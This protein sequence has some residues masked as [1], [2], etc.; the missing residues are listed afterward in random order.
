MGENISDLDLGAILS[1]IKP[2]LVTPHL[3]DI[4]N[5]NND[6]KL[7]EVSQLI[8]KGMLEDF[9][10][11]PKASVPRVIMHE[12]KAT[13][14]RYFD[15]EPLLTGVWPAMS[16]MILHL[17]YGE[18]TMLIEALYPKT[19]QFTAKAFAATFTKMSSVSE[20][21]EV[22]MDNTIEK[23]LDS[24][25][26]G[27]AMIIAMLRD[28]GY[29]PSHPDHVNMQLTNMNELVEAAEKE[30]NFRNAT[31]RAKNANKSQDR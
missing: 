23:K 21:L 7:R 17:S 3:S 19:T 4:T 8:V 10:K 5:I 1:S 15:I 20:P 2:S 18:Q 29:R 13:E 31:T 26:A 25:N 6:K 11:S 14:V 9:N 24:T 22:K 12:G 30:A 27:I 28:E 16:L